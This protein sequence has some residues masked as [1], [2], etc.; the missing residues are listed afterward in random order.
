MDAKIREQ[1]L[2]AKIAV[3]EG[4]GYG[5]SGCIRKWKRELRSLNK[6]SN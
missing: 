2:K 4:K 3:S 5:T 6:K 1:I